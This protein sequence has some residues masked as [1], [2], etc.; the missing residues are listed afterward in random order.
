MQY[1]VKKKGSA[2]YNLGLLI[3]Y[4]TLC[5]IPILPTLSSFLFKRGC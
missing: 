2:F 1:E 4:V 3:K 5:K